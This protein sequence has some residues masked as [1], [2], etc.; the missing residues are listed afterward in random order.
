MLFKHLHSSNNMVGIQDYILHISIATTNIQYLILAM[1]QSSGS[2]GNTIFFVCSAWFLLDSSKVNKKKMLQMLLDIWVVSIIIFIIVYFLRSGNIGLVMILKQ[3]FPT[4]FQNNWY[5]TCYLLFYPIHPFLNWIIKKMDQK[6]LLKTSCILSFL[7]IG[8]N[9]VQDGHFFTSQLILWVTIY[10]M[11]AYMKYYLVDIS[12]NIKINIR[13]FIVGFVG[14]YG[15]VALTNF[16]GL[17]ISIFNDKLLRW[18]S[19]CSPF[20]ILMVIGMLNIARNIHFESSVINNISKLSLLIYIIHENILLRTYYRPLMWQWV[21]TN[22]GYSHVLLQTFILTVIVFAFG[23][24]ASIIYRNTIQ[25]C[26]TKFIN[27]TYPLL[28]RE[29][30]KFETLLLRLH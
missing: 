23:L 9:F 26:V 29:Y 20:I 27:A 28:C 11:I 25:K 14:N 22:M 17:H 10:L 8:V 12:N 15:I 1:L 13:L 30:V 24:I 21:Y 16:L 18:G 2:F 3:I 19:N 6:V 5:M 7:Y 4:T